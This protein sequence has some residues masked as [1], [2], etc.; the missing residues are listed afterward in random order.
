[1][2][3]GFL[4]FIFCVFLVYHSFL[5]Q[6]WTERSGPNRISWTYRAN[7]AINGNGNP[8]GN[9]CKLCG[10]LLTI[11]SLIID[12]NGFRQQRIKS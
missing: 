7:E 9:W 5:S 4:I 11:F 6:S 12:S 10:N 8:S 1:M 2:V 3:N